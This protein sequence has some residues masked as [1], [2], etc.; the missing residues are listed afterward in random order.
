MEFSPTINEDKDVGG[1][2]NFGSRSFIPNITGVTGAH[3]K[4]AV[5]QKMGKIIFWAFELTGTSTTTSS[6]F[7]PPIAPQRL[8]SAATYEAGTISHA[9]VLFSTTGMV[10]MNSNGTYS[11]PDAVT[12][13]GVRRITGWY[14]IK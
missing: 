9:G 6:V 13:N 1:S 4:S 2:K 7:T 5:Y 14:W 12:T 11:I 10:F 8:P 3:T